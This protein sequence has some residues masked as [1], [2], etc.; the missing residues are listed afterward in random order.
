MVLAGTVRDMSDS[1]PV[2]LTLLAFFEYV[3]L[4]LW[5]CLPAA[6]DFD[7]RRQSNY[8]SNDNE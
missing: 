1:F 8:Y 3:S 5:V 4:A 6:S 2:C 7:K